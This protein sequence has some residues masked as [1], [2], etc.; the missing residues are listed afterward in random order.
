MPNNSTEKKLTPIDIRYWATR[1]T[2]KSKLHLHFA[3]VVAELQRRGAKPDTDK[4]KLYMGVSFKRWE[5]LKQGA[6]PTLAEAAAYAEYMSISITD[7]Y[8]IIPYNK[9][10]KA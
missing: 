2:I 7:L 8:K 9:N 3:M 10:K 5:Q 6:A 1:T 4:L